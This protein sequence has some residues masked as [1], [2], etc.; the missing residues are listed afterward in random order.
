MAKILFWISVAVIAFSYVG[1]PLLLGIWSRICRHPVQKQ[2]W[3]PSVSIVLTVH[4]GERYL[5]G[6]LVTLLGLDYPADRLEIALV[7]DGSIDRTM[8]IARGFDDPR[9]R[10]FE[11]PTRRGKPVALNLGVQQARGEIVIFNDV[12]QTMARDAVRE[13]VAN[14][15][16]PAVGAVTGELVLANEG[17]RPQLG[18]Y[19]SYEQWI[20]KKESEI[21]SMVGAAGAFSAIRRS[22]FRPLPEGLILDDVYTPMQIALRGYRTVFDPSARAYDPHDTRSEFRRKL[23]TL[24]GNY[25]VLRLLPEILAPRNPLWLQY[26]CHKLTRLAVPFFLLLL[27]GAN[28]WLHSGFYAATLVAQFGFYV[29]ALSFRQLRRFPGLATVSAASF[30]FLMANSAALLGLLFFFRGKKNIWV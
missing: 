19:Y 3:L 21:H 18:L 15:R 30:S 9:L 10:L 22:L 2:P 7:S 25:Q 4:D 24:T 11:L 14:F 12:R 16:D 8:E 20:R 13:L 29:T 28:L 17:L 5:K 6:K 23:R 1:Y 26:V 27:L